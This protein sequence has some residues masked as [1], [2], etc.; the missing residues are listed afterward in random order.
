MGLIQTKDKTPSG[1]LVPN[2][3]K[4][5]FCCN[6]I[7]ILLAV[8][9]WTRFEAHE[10]VPLGTLASLITSK[11]Q[12]TVTWLESALGSGPNGAALLDELSQAGESLDR[13]SLKATPLN[14]RSRG[15]SRLGKESLVIRLEAVTEPSSRKLSFILKC[16][17]QGIGNSYGDPLLD[18]WL[19]R[20]M[21]VNSIQ[22]RELHPAFFENPFA[23]HIPQNNLGTTVAR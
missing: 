3:V 8:L 18:E 23:N 20:R 6:L 19:R 7:L 5:A 16:W 15:S 22:V 21:S 10:A 12:I 1:Y 17:A 4:L 11:D 2:V 9:C 13:E 14:L